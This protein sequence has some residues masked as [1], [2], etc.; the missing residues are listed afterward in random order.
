MSSR[1]EDGGPTLPPQ[2]SEQAGEDLGDRESAAIEPLVEP[3]EQVRRDPM[4]SPKERRPHREDPRERLSSGRPD[5]VGDLASRAAGDGRRAGARRARDPDDPRARGVR[6]RRVEA[7]DDLIH[8][9]SA[10]ENHGREPVLR[11]D[12]RVRGRLHQWT[13]Y[14][15]L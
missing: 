2:P 5:P 14:Y 3:P 6:G 8:F 11:K 7:A 13:Y 4:R 15:E 1:T 10:A 12:L 9:P